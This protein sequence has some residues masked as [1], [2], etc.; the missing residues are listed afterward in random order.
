MPRTISES[1]TPGS[2][3][4][5]AGR[6]LTTKDPTSAAATAKR[7][8]GLRRFTTFTLSNALNR[9]ELRG[10]DGKFNHGRLNSGRK[11]TEGQ[12]VG[13]EFAIKKR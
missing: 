2:P 1:L 11:V 9:S 12:G 7:E 13:E 10:S 3:A 8:K 6:V 4:A 5:D